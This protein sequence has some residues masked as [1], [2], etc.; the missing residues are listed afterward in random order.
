MRWSDGEYVDGLRQLARLYCEGGA[1]RRLCGA[2]RGCSEEVGEG[3]AV[4]AGATGEA[5]GDWGRNSGVAMLVAEDDGFEAGGLAEAGPR[6][7]CR[8][9]GELS[10]RSRL[11]G[12]EALMALH[13]FDAV[14]EGEVAGATLEPR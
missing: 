5:F 6:R 2:S 10:A 3:S 7:T 1:R 14:G 4:R 8:Q 11:A 9:P 13:V 12:V